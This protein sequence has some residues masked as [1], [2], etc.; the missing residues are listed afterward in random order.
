MLLNSFYVGEPFVRWAN[1]SKL[2]EMKDKINSDQLTCLLFEA[3]E[4]KRR[5][6]KS[7]QLTSAVS[8]HSIQYATLSNSYRIFTSIYT[9]IILFLTNS[10]SKG[11]SIVPYRSLSKLY[12]YIVRTSCVQIIL[13]MILIYR[14]GDFIFHHLLSIV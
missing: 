14:K 7:F 1:Q 11:K 10:P 6:Y 3:S 9:N 2:P 13:P 4:N 8:D 5:I 12:K